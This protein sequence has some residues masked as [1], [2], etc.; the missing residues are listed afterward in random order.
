M[1]RGGALSIQG[2]PRFGTYIGETL[3]RHLYRGRI[4][5]PNRQQLTKVFHIEHKYIYTYDRNFKRHSTTQMTEGR[6]T[7]NHKKGG[8]PTLIQGEEKQPPYTGRTSDPPFKQENCNTT[9][10]Q[11]KRN[12]HLIQGEEKPD[13]IRGETTKSKSSS[14][15]MS[16]E[17]TSC[18]YCQT[19]DNQIS[20]HFY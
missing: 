3:V 19:G 14:L 5:L 9:L 12:P 15:P 17:W 16:A 11:G 20:F 8:K 2:E 1:F 10:I 18:K 13:P 7:H 4:P 6:D